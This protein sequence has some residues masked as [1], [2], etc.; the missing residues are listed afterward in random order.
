MG[1]SVEVKRGVSWSKEQEHSEP[2]PSRVPVIGI[3]NVQDRLEL[4]DMLYLSG[5]KPTAV[6]KARVSAGWTVMVGSN[7]NRARI[8][9]A[10][11]VREDVEFL[12]ASFLIGTK[13]TTDSGLTSDY[14][15]RWLT[16]DQV[17]SYLSA[18]SEGTTGLNNLSHSFFRRM[19]IPVPGPNEQAAIAR[20]L[21]AVDTALEGTRAVLERAREVKRALVQR[22]LSNGLRGEP[23]RKTAIGHVPRSWGVVS[24]SSVVPTFQYGLSVPMEAKGELPILR[25]GNIQDGD[26][27]LSDLK[28]VNLPPKVVEPYLLHRGDVLFNR[29]NSQEWVGKVGIYRQDSRAVFASYL[30]RLLPDATRIDKYYL[31]HVLGSYSAQCRIKRYATPG[32]QQVNINATNLGKVLI[33]VP[34]GDDGLREQREIA[35]MLE[36]G[37]AAFRSYEPVLAAQQALK[38]SLMHDLLTG[39]V[40]VRDEEKAAAS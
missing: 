13:P 31:G 33:P 40:R 7:G 35:A 11:L 39:V 27:L 8:G 36:A 18:S 20:I 16:T 5:L 26:V 1:R 38:K 6:E 30:I 4:T 25:M 29:T 14:F 10:V 32:V 9:N 24:V 34:M 15:Y 37:E 17:Q 23:T 2:G 28:F 3:R 22:V 12:F 21:D 19:A